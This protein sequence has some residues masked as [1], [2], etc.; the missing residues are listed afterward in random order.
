M[1]SNLLN[2]CFTNLCL[3]RLI[4]TK[5]HAKYFIFNKILDMQRTNG[6]AAR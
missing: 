2:L 4:I 1:K 3:N 5:P 6:L